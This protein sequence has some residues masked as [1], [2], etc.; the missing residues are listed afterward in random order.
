[1]TV[2]SSAVGHAYKA[3]QSIYGVD[4]TYQRPSTSQSVTISKAVPGRS[5]HDVSQDGMVIEQ[6]KSRDFLILAS[7]L[8]LGGAETLPR[9]GDRII[10]GSKTFAILAMGTEAQWKWTDQSQTVLRVHTREM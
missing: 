5:E 4:V 3:M 10:E 9:K 6:V 2:F 7:A 1:M 8:Q